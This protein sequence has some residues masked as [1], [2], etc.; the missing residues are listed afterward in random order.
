MAAPAGP[1]NGL[2]V[3]ERARVVAIPLDANGNKAS[4]VPGSASW[5]LGST[6]VVTI[7]SDTG[8]ELYQIAEALAPGTATI[9]F[10][11]SDVFSNEVP[12][13]TTATVLDAMALHGE[14][15]ERYG[16]DILGMRTGSMS[17]EAEYTVLPRASSTG[18]RYFWMSVTAVDFRRSMGGIPTYELTPSDKV[19]GHSSQ[20]H[21]LVNFHAANSSATSTGTGRRFKINIFSRGTDTLRFRATTAGTGT[22]ISGSVR[23]SIIQPT[24]ADLSTERF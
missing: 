16:V 10:S 21:A 20:G 17:S 9:H 14:I 1:L 18:D 12:A 19:Y 6:G 4:I 24:H 15:G 3:G 13:E 7:S 8:G 5:S 22:P 11:G 23:L 2:R